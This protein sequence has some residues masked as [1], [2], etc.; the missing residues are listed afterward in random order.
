MNRKKHGDQPRHGRNAEIEAGSLRERANGRLEAYPTLRRKMMVAV[1]LFAVSVVVV[2]VLFADWYYGLPDDA[3]AEFVGRQSCVQCHEAQQSEWTGSHHDLA[4]DV[5]KEMTVLGDFKDAE[6]THL[7]VTSRMFRRDGKYFVNTEGPDGK[8]AD[9][10]VK[11]VF[12]VDP[13]QQYLV[14]FDRPADM[15]ANEVARL[16]VLRIS[17]DT[18]NKRWFHLDPPDVKEKLEPTDELHWTG[19]AQRWNHMCADCHSTNL[20]KNFDVAKLQYHTT[21][22]EIDVSC[23]AC[24]G[25]GSLH[26]ELANSKSLFWDRKRGYALAG[27]KVASNVPQVQACAPCHSRRRVLAPGYTAGCNYYDY[28]ANEALT[29]AAYYADGQIMDEVYEYTSFLESKMFHKNI[30]CSDCHDPHSAKLKHTGNQVCTSCHQHPAGKYDGQNHHRHP[31]SSTGAQCVE[32]H[33]PQTTYMEVDPRRDHSLRVPRPDLSVKLGT[34]NACTRCHLRDEVL[35]GGANAGGSGLGARG[36]GGEGLAELV[37]RKDLK[38]YADWLAAGRRGDEGVKTRLAE[39]DAWADATLDVWYGKTRKKEPHFAEALA[40][41]RAMTPDAPAKLQELLNNRSQPA[42]ARASA[43]LELAAYAEP[44]TEVVKALYKALGDRDPQVRSAAVLSLQSAGGAED[45]NTRVSALATLL[46]DKTRL[47]RTE[48]ARGLAMQGFQVL[49]GEEREAFKKALDECFAGAEVDNDRA[50]GH[51][52][53]ALLNEGLGDL[54]EAEAEYETALKVEPNSIGPRTNL[55][56]M[57]DRQL[58]ETEQRVRQLVQQGNRAAAEREIEAV[59]KLPERVYRLREEELGLLERDVVLAPDNA[60]I[61]G[62]I[63]L[64]RYLAGW[65]K[66]AD[67][68]LLTAAL[69]EPRNPEQLFRLAIY[70]RDTNRIPDAIQLVDRLLKLRPSSRAFQNFAEELKQQGGNAVPDAPNKT[71]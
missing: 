69:L 2:A 15:P 48:A 51:M 10:E 50:A 55:A 24:H 70:Y 67:A 22:S 66:E 46:N 18:R 44:G 58:Q 56:A 26:V 42:V 9:F 28:F 16:Q 31:M 38:E 34:P 40:A 37:A 5:A 35:P 41:A 27:L 19:L 36:S 6:L 59:R 32:C 25:P 13:L 3:T 39:V 30:R 7:G 8:N 21:W 52:S 68:A 12:G 17:W 60:P 61:Q 23:E 14:E 57:Y 20:Q 33:M 11:Y 4:M 65:T 63:G 71:N 43:A 64:A 29:P 62:R 54:D 1:G 47:L 49:R 53:I 45:E